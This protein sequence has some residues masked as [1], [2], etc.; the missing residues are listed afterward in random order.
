MEKDNR[1]EKA[2]AMFVKLKEHI[3]ENV[4]YTA[5]DYGVKVIGTSKLKNVKD[6]K[7]VEIGNDS[8]PFVGFGAAILSIVSM[9]FEVLYSNPYIE[10]GYD[11]R[12]DKDI[13]ESK[14]L[15]FGDE[16]VPSKVKKKRKIRK[17]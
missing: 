8:I 5:W 10:N 1:K 12:T 11:R 14:R 13:F 3:G 7:C 15:I 17:K 16:I 4:T 9:D 6:F 2:I